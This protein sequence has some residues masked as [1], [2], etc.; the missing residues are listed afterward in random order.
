MIKNTLCLHLDN[1]RCEKA[2]QYW[3]RSR[4]YDGINL[5]LFYMELDVVGPNSLKPFII[6]AVLRRSV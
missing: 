6:L 2:I 5:V 1:Q 4:L 3:A